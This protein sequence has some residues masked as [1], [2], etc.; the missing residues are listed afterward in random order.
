MNGEG[1]DGG[2]KMLGVDSSKLFAPTVV[3]VINI[4]H[5]VRH[6]PGPNSMNF[7]HLQKQKRGNYFINL[8]VKE[9]DLN[10]TSSVSG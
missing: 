8:T 5:L 6:L 3:F 2:C 7:K 1:V 4:H 9:T 10:S